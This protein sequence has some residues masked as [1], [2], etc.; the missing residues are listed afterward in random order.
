VLSRPSS[1]PAEDQ[2]DELRNPRFRS[3]DAT[4]ESRYPC[5]RRK[6]TYSEHS[7][8]TSTQDRL[9]WDYELR[10]GVMDFGVGLDVGCKNL[11]VLSKVS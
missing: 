6:T 2:R 8:A 9:S 7:L 3:N 4:G 10:K 5:F 11:G 1:S